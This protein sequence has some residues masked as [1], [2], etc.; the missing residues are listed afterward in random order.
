MAVLFTQGK[1]LNETLL[2][3][4]RGSQKLW[5]AY[6]QKCPSLVWIQVGTC[7]FELIY[8]QLFYQSQGSY[9][10]LVFSDEKYF[11]FVHFRYWMKQI[12]FL[13]CV[14]RSGQY[15][16]SDWLRAERGESTYRNPAYNTHLSPS[17]YLNRHQKSMHWK[18]HRRIKGWTHKHPTSTLDYGLT[19]LIQ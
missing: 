9:R 10:G 18:Q 4:P 11:T 7:H 15:F 6:R 8:C 5:E 14:Y 19:C 12:N 1:S 3:F 2:I 13:D 16:L 17:V